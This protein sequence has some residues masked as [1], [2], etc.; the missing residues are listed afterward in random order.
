MHLT[1]VFDVSASPAVVPPAFFKEFE[2]PRLIKL[3]SHFA[4]SAAAANWLHI[5]S[6]AQSI[7]SFYP[8]IGANIANFDYSVSYDEALKQLPNTC[9]DGNIKPLDFVSASPDTIAE[10][11]NLLISKSSKKGGFILFSGCEI[12]PEAKIDNIKAMVQAVR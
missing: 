1:L 3:F 6:P 11:A 5:P 4:K 8:K 7:M 2:I 10:S 12:P 9:L